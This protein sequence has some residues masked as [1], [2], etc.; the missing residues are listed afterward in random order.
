MF[1]L[2]FSVGC[3]GKYQCF[4]IFRVKETECSSDVSVSAYISARSQNSEHRQLRRGQHPISQTSVGS[5]HPDRRNV[6]ELDT[7]CASWQRILNETSSVADL[8]NVPCPTLS[9]PRTTSRCGRHARQLTRL[10]R[11]HLQK[12]RP[13]EVNVLKDPKHRMWEI[14]L[15]S[16]VA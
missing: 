2:V 4:A 9:I 8:S 5:V 16:L 12:N 6:I 13:H 3:A 15:K 10:T 1:M 7:I 14:Q 11:R